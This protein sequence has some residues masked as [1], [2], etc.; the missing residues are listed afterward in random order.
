MRELEVKEVVQLGETKPFVPMTDLK[1][2]NRA[3]RRRL[4]QLRGRAMRRVE[5]RKGNK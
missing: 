4:D 3:E 5:R 1:P 2:M